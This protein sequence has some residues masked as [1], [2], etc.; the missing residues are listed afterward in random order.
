MTLLQRYVDCHTF[1]RSEMWRIHR[2]VAFIFWAALWVVLVMLLVVAA[3]RH[4]VA[5]AF[6]VPAGIGL[7][8]L[9]IGHH[10]GHHWLGYRAWPF[11]GI[12][13]QAGCGCVGGDGARIPVP[14]LRSVAHRP[15]SPGSRRAKGGGPMTG[16]GPLSRGGR[17][18]E[19][20]AAEDACV[21]CREAT[22]APT[23]DTGKRPAAAD[24]RAVVLSV[25]GL[26]DGRGGPGPVGPG[27]RR[28]RFWWTG[29][30]TWPTT[31]PARPVWR[32]G[33]GATAGAC[34]AW[35]A[36]I[37]Q[38]RGGLV[39]SVMSGPLVLVGASGVSP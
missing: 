2:R 9:A 19:A 5:A 39:A 23:P 34:R 14:V 16:H 36:T 12:G 30:P 7:V 37:G 38:L 31:S 8:S 24:P 27:Q 17:R 13:D 11:D 35:R 25:A 15:P 20:A 32:D 22:P 29:T 10:D 1:V 21:A 4:F 26:A 18:K 33:R 3:Q 28:R 6:A